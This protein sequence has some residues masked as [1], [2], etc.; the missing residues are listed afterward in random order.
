MEFQTLTYEKDL[1][2]S[3]EASLVQH[4]FNEVEAMLEN[5]F[6]LFTVFRPLRCVFLFPNRTCHSMAEMPWRNY[7]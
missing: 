2:L 3:S 4:S 5:Y 1:H 7:A 6:S